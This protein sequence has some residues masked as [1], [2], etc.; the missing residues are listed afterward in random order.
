[1]KLSIWGALMRE[2]LRLTGGLPV[3]KAAFPKSTVFYYSV[4]TLLAT[5]MLVGSANAEERFF[6][7]VDL[8]LSI[9]IMHQEDF[10][11]GSAL[12]SEILNRD[13]GGLVYETRALSTGEADV[14]IFVLPTWRTT[15]GLPFSDSLEGHY[16]QINE[17]PNGADGFTFNV[18]F[19]DGRQMGL[20]FLSEQVFQRNT[21]DC[22]ASIFYIALGFGFDGGRI[23][24][25]NE[26]DC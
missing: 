1:V 12:F 17:L 4:I 3:F 5:L 26:P 8:P 18:I 15:D 14:L 25:S 23:D 19:S 9:A 22:G 16:R 20:V 11:D 21:A 24:I 2:T 7:N 13:Y 6:R 10:S